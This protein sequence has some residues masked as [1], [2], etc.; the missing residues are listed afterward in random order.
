MKEIVPGQVYEAQNGRSKAQYRVLRRVGNDTSAWLCEVAVREHLLME[1][2]LV[3]EGGEAVTPT[4]TKIV[5]GQVYEAWDGKTKVRYRVLKVLRSNSSPE[6]EARERVLL[7]G[8]LVSEAGEV[9]EPTLEH[10]VQVLEAAVVH[11]YKKGVP[12]AA[13]GK[14]GCV[15]DRMLSLIRALYIAHERRLMAR[16]GPPADVDEAWRAEKEAQ[17]DMLRYVAGLEV[18]AAASLDK[19]CGR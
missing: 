19:V 12:D 2:H 7:Q 1:G 17:E 15:S 11:L 8:H 13:P 14:A 6:A 18:T 5:P 10:R 16:G 9:A 4:P 3:S